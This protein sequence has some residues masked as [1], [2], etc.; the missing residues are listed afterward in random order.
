M[1]NS[2]HRGL[3][4]GVVKLVP[5]RGA[6]HRNMRHGCFEETHM[7]KLK[8]VDASSAEQKLRCFC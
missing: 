4:R 5:Q 1:N 2:D 6:S 3:V 7:K 8:I